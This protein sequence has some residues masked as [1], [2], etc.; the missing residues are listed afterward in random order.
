MKEKNTVKS[1]GTALLVVIGVFMYIGGFGNVMTVGF[2]ASFLGEDVIRYVVFVILFFIVGCLSF[3]SAWG[4]WKG[5]KWA[6]GTGII[7]SISG[8]IL[9]SI[10]IL[11]ALASLKLSF[12]EKYPQ[13]K[14]QIYAGMTIYIFVLCICVAT[15][16]LLIVL[17][18]SSAQKRRV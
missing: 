17:I 7:T 3:V 4:L 15:M 5:K 11:N 12:Y 10:G 13:L 18:I 16:I 14:A 9:E 1:V 6:L 2:Y 8:I